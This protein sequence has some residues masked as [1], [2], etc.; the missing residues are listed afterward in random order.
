MT[1]DLIGVL[2][3]GCSFAVLALVQSTACLGLN[4]QWGQTGLFNVGVAGIV[5]MGAYTSA[6]LTASAGAGH[7]GGLGWPIVLGCLGAM[8]VA[9]GLSMLLGQ[10]TLRLS[11][12]TLAITTFGAAV[13]IDLVIRNALPLTGGPLGIG[14]IPR[15]FDSLASR[16][17]LHEFV[18]LVW[19][20]AVVGLVYHLLERLVSSPYGRVLRALREDERAAAALGKSPRAY[21]LSAFALGGALMGLAGALEAH[22]LGFI[23]PE[24]FSSALTF[25]VWAMLIVGGSGNN[26]GALLG[27]FVIVALWSL[28]GLF[29]TALLPADLQ[30]RGAALRIAVIGVLLVTII[31]KRPRGL[32]GERVQ[33]SRHLDEP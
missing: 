25:Q 18:T 32:I 11:A 15:P 19:V 33:V 16:P 13:V 2:T 22:T 3:Y 14:F 6:L 9:G 28:T 30:A 21:R 12:D 5:A 8:A 1:V 10:L 4:L 27:T 24:N 26:R 29:T 23:A 17:L 7:L 31:V 20:A